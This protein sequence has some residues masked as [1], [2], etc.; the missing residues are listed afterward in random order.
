VNA[1]DVIEMENDLE[2]RRIVER[3]SVVVHV[4]TRVCPQRKVPQI[5]V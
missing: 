2:L 4:P 5:G 3:P 1:P